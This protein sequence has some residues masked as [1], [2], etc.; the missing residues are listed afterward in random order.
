VPTAPVP[1]PGRKLLLGRQPCTGLD[2]P[3]ALQRQRRA[4][5][6]LLGAEASLPTQDPEL[7]PDVC[8][9]P[10]TP[11]VLTQGLAGLLGSGFIH[12]LLPP[13]LSPQADHAQ[14]FQVTSERR[15]R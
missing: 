14:V 6:Q 12:G 2:R 3:N 10:P 15:T 4:L 1:W 9:G 7:G 5:R 8:E 11:D 13:P